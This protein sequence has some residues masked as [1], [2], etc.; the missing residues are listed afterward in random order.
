[1]VAVNRLITN[2]LHNIFFCVQQKEESQLEA[3]KIT[4]VNMCL[5]FVYCCRVSVTHSR[6]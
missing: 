1:M 3:E 6:V 2:I 4:E 5:V